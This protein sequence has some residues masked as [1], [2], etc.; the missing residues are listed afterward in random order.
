[1]NEHD[2]EWG[3]TKDA[4]FYADHKL[5]WGPGRRTVM[6]AFANGAQL[7][8]EDICQRFNMKRKTVSARRTEL[9]RLGFVMPIGMKKIHRQRGQVWTATASG[10]TQI[11]VLMKLYWIGS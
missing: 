4:K 2:N 5:Q 8:D 9:W 1:M 6:L 3:I 10:I 7:A 11:N